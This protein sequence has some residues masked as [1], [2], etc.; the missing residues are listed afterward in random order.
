ML[1]TVMSMAGILTFY[2]ATC[3]VHRKFEMDQVQDISSHRSNLLKI[4]CL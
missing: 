3:I 4:L 2:Q 1:I